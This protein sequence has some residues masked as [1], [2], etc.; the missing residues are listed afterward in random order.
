MSPQKARVNHHSAG[1][2]CGCKPGFIALWFLAQPVN[3]ARFFFNFADWPV[4][5]NRNITFGFY[6]AMIVIGKF[7]HALPEIYALVGYPGPPEV[8]RGPA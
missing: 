2:R 1:K 6:D 4:K 7:F 3:V 5:D 8:P